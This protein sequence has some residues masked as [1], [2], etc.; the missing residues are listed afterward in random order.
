MPAEQ[1][2]APLSLGSRRELFVDR[3]LI[4]EMQDARLLLHCPERREA[5]FVCDAPWE[6]DIAGFYSVFQ[7]SETVRLYYRAS[8]PDRSNEDLVVFA[9]AESDDGGLSF[10]RPELG[11]VEFKGSKRNN[12]L[13]I[14]EPPFVPPPAFKD[15][16]PACPPDQRYKGLSARWRK[17]FAMASADGLRWRPLSEDPVEMEGTFDTV[18]T[19]FWDSRAGCYRCYTRY[20]EDLDGPSPVRAIQSATSPDFIHWSSV[21]HNRYDDPYADMQL[22]TNSSLPCPGAEHFYIAFPNRFVEDRTPDPDHPYPGVNDALFMASRDGEAW[23]RYP[24][25]WVRPGLDRLNWTERNNY[26]TWGI[27]ETSLSEWSLYI[28]ERY[29]HPGVPGRLRRLSVRPHGFVSL[30]ANY[31]GGSVLTRPFTFAGSRLHLNYS[32]SAAGSVRI[33]LCG[34]S[35]APLDGCDITDTPPLYGDALDEPIPWDL[36]AFRG[37]PVRLRFELK[38]ADIFALQFKETV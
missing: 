31:S 7:D 29:R 28:S 19:A 30:H 2:N 20:F 36:S 3:W 17:L 25:A 5:A 10:R 8:I 21:R 22:Y 13:H 38:D 14:G 37:R 24:E 11:L 12:I 33:A 6:D 4:E 27:I 18:N 32:A 34:V 16:N 26:P 15:T 23:T 9:L 35:G 1:Q